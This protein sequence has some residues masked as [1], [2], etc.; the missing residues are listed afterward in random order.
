MEAG[1]R[2]GD[3]RFCQFSGD[4]MRLFKSRQQGLA[5]KPLQPQRI[6]RLHQLKRRQHALSGERAKQT[7]Q[8]IGDLALRLA[9]PHGGERLPSFVD[10]VF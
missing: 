4:L 7:A 6:V 1:L 10:G 8:L 2:G 9:A 5:E 3:V